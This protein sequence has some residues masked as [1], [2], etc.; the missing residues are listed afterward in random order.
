MQI[1][2][3]LHTCEDYSLLTNYII[4]S[5][6]SFFSFTEDCI[7][8]TVFKSPIIDGPLMDTEQSRIVFLWEQESVLTLLDQQI[9]IVSGH[10]FFP[11]Q[12]INNLNSI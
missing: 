7:L 12:Q 8:S 1:R 2:Y 6:L 3:I 5:K 4:L 10:V 9:L 11:K